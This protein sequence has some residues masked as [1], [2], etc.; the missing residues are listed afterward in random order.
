MK[1]RICKNGYDKYKIE[2][3]YGCSFRWNPLQRLR[4]GKMLRFTSMEEAEK[5][6]LYEKRKDKIKADNRKKAEWACMGEY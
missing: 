2:Y 1:Y 5:Q 3:K 4:K 6:I